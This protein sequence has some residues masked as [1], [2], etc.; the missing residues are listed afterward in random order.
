M[1]TVQSDTP[2]AQKV[3]EGRT[4]WHAMPPP[5]TGDALVYT[6]FGCYVYMQ[7]FQRSG[8]R[9]LISSPVPGLRLPRKLVP[10]CKAFSHILLC[11]AQLVHYGVQVA[12]RST[13]LTA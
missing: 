10:V 4:Q 8:G 13:A 1:G 3:I 6:A 5:R 9:P 12:A 7:V 11:A 2:P